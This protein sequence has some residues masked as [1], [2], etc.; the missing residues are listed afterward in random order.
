MARW[1]VTLPLTRPN[2]STFICGAVLSGQEG[3]SALRYQ[4]DWHL[5]LAFPLTGTILALLGLG[6]AMHLGHR[7]GIAIGVGIG[8]MVTGLY[9][10]AIQVGGSLGTA[11]ILPPY[12]A[13]WSS[14]VL[15]GALGLW[16]LRR[17]PQ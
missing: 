16:L 15:F 4:V 5:R 17:A 7:G 12:L 9:L 8:I 6:I 1:R 3:Y 14:N 10:T 2:L 11:G 13:V